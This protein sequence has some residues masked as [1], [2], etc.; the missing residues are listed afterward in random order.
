MTTLK[1]GGQFALA[2]FRYVEGEEGGGHHHDHSH[3]HA[4]SHSHGHNHGD[5]HKSHHGG[6]VAYT[7]EEIRSLFVKSGLE[8]SKEF[9]PFEFE[10][11]GVMRKCV[12]AVGTKL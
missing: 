7:D 3:S 1:K 11:G 12:M 9:T 10:W 4:H 2:E 8:P 6:H 5:D